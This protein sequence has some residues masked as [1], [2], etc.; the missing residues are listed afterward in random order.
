[1][2]L[3][4]VPLKEEA[5]KLREG[6][7]KLTEIVTKTGLSKATLKRFFKKKGL[8]NDKLSLSH[9]KSAPSENKDK[10][11]D[12]NESLT[13]KSE[14]PD[15]QKEVKEG[16]EI[17]INNVSFKGAK[18]DF[19][20]KNGS[21]A[22]VSS[23]VVIEK[24]IEQRRDPTEG[25]GVSDSPSES[26]I[27]PGLGQDLQTSHVT[28]KLDIDAPDNVLDNFFSRGLV[29]TL[30]PIGLVTAG[31]LMKGKLGEKGEYKE[32]GGDAW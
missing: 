30:I 20:V 18:V 15:T 17:E 22:I 14:V 27:K 11:G 9:I 13:I 25:S 29:E 28:E 5:L 10:E 26:R 8:V 2:V 24:P 32:R 12:K 4:N 19:D 6:G 21:L 23:D 3:K 7:M 1:M 31:F 16:S